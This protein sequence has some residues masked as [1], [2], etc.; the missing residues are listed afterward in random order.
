MVQRDMISDLALSVFRLNRLMLDY[1]QHLLDLEGEKEVQITVA[2]VLLPLL[3]REGLTLSELARNLNM[4]APTVTVI[5][6]RLEE[7]GLIRRERGTDDRRQV[8]LYLT[9]AGKVKAEHF[10][11]VEKKVLGKMSDGIAKDNLKQ[12]VETLKSVFSNL[13]GKAH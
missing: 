12:T 5:A 4:K 9:T 10:K 6:N 1:G 3:D 7:K 2:G 11:R 13:E 8:H